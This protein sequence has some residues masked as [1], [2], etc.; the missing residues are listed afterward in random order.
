MEEVFGA[1]QAWRTVFEHSPIG[2]A[3]VSLDGDWLAVNEA[4]SSMLGFSVD[5][6]SRMTFQEITHPDDL[7]MDL[8]LLR[9]CLAG[10]IP[11]YRVG[12]R[13]LR[14]DG[15][16]LWGDLSVALVR[17]ENGAPMHFISQILDVT[18][19]RAAQDELTRALA[20]VRRHRRVSEAVFASVDVGL[21]LIDA[22]GRYEQMNEA[23]RRFMALAFPEGH[24]GV[25][26]Q[27][28]EVYAGDTGP[29]IAAED[30]PS[31]RA[32]AGE[33]FDDA[34]MWV[35]A[36]PADRRALSVSSRAIRGADGEFQAAAL[37]YTDVTEL[38]RALEV[39]DEFVASVSHELRTPL[40]ALLGYLELMA[41]GIETKSEMA[42]FLDVARRNGERLAF[43][44]SDLLEVAAD[45]RGEMRLLRRRTDVARVV[46]EG[47]RAA[48]PI[49]ASTGIAMTVEIPDRLDADVDGD[50]LRQVVD[51]LLS[52]AIK[53][54]P[55]GGAVSVRLS[56]VSQDLRLMVSDSG[57]GVDMNDLDQLFT[58]FYRSSRVRALQI[59]GTGL[60]LAIVRSIVDA[61]GGEITVESEAA[62]G[63]MFTVS[64]PLAQPVATTE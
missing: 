46:R 44:V 15:T 24:D 39:K 35:G 32:A 25:A 41:D 23:H 38:I 62:G 11:S 17:D 28:G 64:L 20:E 14:A 22:D 9:Q 5:E 45:S 18:A 21:V 49:A 55:G 47:V 57:I 53:Y 19:Q 13:Y 12:K 26:G 30:M 48:A 6:F 31:R 8:G 54:T 56:V 34:R 3:L 4:L 61:H 40:T 1:D 29:R 7:A 16:L 2:M 42:G 51:N 50:R 52:N 33:E 27:L 63:S 58:R 43:L 59:P 10:E 36:D 37:A 60:G